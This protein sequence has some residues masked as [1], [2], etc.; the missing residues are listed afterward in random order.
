MN[1]SFSDVNKDGVSYVENKTLN[2]HKNI[3]LDSEIDVV[4]NNFIIMDEINIYANCS[5]NNVIFKGAMLY[6][7]KD[8]VVEFNKCTFYSRNKLTTIF[9]DKGARSHIILKECTFLNYKTAVTVNDNYIDTIEN[10]CFQGCSVA[11]MIDSPESIS[12]C[13]DIRDNVMISTKESVFINIH[14]YDEKDRSLIRRIQDIT[15]KNNYGRIL[16][17]NINKIDTYSY[18]V[19]NDDELRS[20]LP[21]IGNGNIIYMNGDLFY[22]NIEINKKI[23]IIGSKNCRLLPKVNEKNDVA[24][25]IN[26]SN[27]T[28]LNI[29]I[30]N[31]EKNFF[32]DGIKFSVLGGCECHLE[33][34]EIDNVTRRGISLWGKNTQNTIINN[35]VFK[36]INGGAALNIIGSCEISNCFFYNCHEVIL[37]KY[38]EKLILQNCIFKNI[39]TLITINKNILSSILLKNNQYNGVNE[40]LNEIE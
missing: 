34:I 38:D 28:I 40:F 8:V 1:S 13:S 33:N 19:N 12:E 37:K 31:N 25:M 15:V 30:T 4:G 24:I 26:S 17:G 39:Y 22:G 7:K 10:N 29:Q 36:N 20:I 5:F 3:I 35:C 16:C 14:S 23:M 18:Y 27:V 32:R 6:I 11:V 9:M 2:S 21:N